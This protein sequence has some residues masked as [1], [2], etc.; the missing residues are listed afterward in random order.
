MVPTGMGVRQEK[1]RERLE[2]G[3]RDADKRA[4]EKAGIQGGATPQ[5]GDARVPS[6]GAITSTFPQEKGGIEKTERTQTDTSPPGVREV[7]EKEG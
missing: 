7:G 6:Q 1:E 3:A 2:A 5:K 4:E